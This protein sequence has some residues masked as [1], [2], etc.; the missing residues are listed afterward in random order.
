M[1]ERHL[2]EKD[3]ASLGGCQMVCVPVSKA[4]C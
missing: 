3:Q 2:I 1:T 4:R